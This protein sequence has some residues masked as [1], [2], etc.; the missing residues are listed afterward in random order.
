KLASPRVLRHLD[1]IKPEGPASV[2]VVLRS[3]PDTD[4]LD[5]VVRVLPLGMDL[6]YAAFPYRL[7]G[8]EGELEL[9]PDGALVKHLRGKTTGGETFLSGRIDGYEW[10]GSFLFDIRI[11]GMAIDDRLLEACSP[12]LRTWFEAFELK[13]LLRLRGNIAK[14]RGENAEVR[15]PAL[16]ELVDSTGRYKNFPYPLT[17]MNGTM[18]VDFPAVRVDRLRARA[19]DAEVDLWGDLDVTQGRSTVDLRIDARG[20]PLDAVLRAALPPAAVKVFDDFQP[21]GRT[22]VQVRLL[23]AAGESEPRYHFL[24]NLTGASARYTGVP[25]PVE[26]L[27][28]RVEGRI[29]PG[30]VRAQ[31]DAVRGRYGESDVR[32][33]GDY[34]E[35][36]ERRE[37]N[38][39]VRASNLPI[40]EELTAAL[41]EGVRTAIVKTA[42]KGTANVRLEYGSVGDAARFSAEIGLMQSAFEIDV[43]V[44][45]VE[46][47]LYL[48][49]STQRESGGI[50]ILGRI[51]LSNARIVGKRF[52]SLSGS[53]LLNQNRLTL[54]NILGTAY[55]GVV[56]GRL[57]TNLDT[58][59]FEAGL[60]ASGID[61]QQMRQDTE[62]YRQKSL[63]GRLT[64]TIPEVR[65]SFGKRDTIRGSGELTVW[66]GSLWSVPIFLKVLSLNVSKWGSSSKFDAGVVKFDIKEE[67]FK[68]RSA[69]FRSEEASLIGEGYLDFD[70]NMNLILKVETEPLGDFWL[71]KPI[72]VLI[73]LF[74]NSFWGVEVQGS[75]D[76]PSVGLKLF[77]RRPK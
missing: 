60:Q 3:R 35:K 51:D 58:G 21:G 39:E 59:E 9:Y 25:L 34:S 40:T 76:D 63:A 37:T 2:E 43:P 53:L 26:G 15:V 32:L 33:S 61:L 27:S 66:D 46:G 14:E 75:F 77:P 72:N 74:S 8:C 4:K 13:G 70:L 68:I 7:K 17:K 57:S 56:T 52:S 49:G 71:F 28:G 73:N 1:K 41:P 36:G 44:R 30:E 18:F 69:I 22:D 23:Q 16:V 42:M 48:T 12:E 54:S 45:E 24:A 65:G 38:V 29:A 10:P 64:I 6:S 5:V 67:K 47:K 31:W 50:G 62:G 19:Q 55:D 11:D 20:L